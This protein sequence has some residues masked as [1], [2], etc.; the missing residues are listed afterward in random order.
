MCVCV[1]VCVVCV[2]MD[3][4]CAGMECVV[5]EEGKWHGMGLYGRIYCIQIQIMTLSCVGTLALMKVACSYQSI[6]AMY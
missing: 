4:K 3:V 5:F 6:L 1:C 2:E